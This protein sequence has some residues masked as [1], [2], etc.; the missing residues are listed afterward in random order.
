MKPYAKEAMLPLEPFPAIR[1]WHA[2]LEAL[3]GWR[4]AFEGLSAR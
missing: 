2:R 3:D 1:A 4:N